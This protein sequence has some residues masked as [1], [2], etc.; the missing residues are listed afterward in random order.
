MTAPALKLMGAAPGKVPTV[1]SPTGR[2]G[3]PN[4]IASLILTL[5]GPGGAYCNGS[6]FLSDGGRLSQQPSVT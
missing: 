2:A 3:Y 4:E 6:V 5:A 1:V